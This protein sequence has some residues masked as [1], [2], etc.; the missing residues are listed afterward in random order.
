M[1]VLP[2]P[3]CSHLIRS[4]MAQRLT[5]ASAACEQL[6][7]QDATSGEVI[8]PGMSLRI[9]AC[10]INEIPPFPTLLLKRREEGI[11]QHARI[12]LHLEHLPDGALGRQRSARRGESYK[13]ISV[14]WRPESCWI[15]KCLQSAVDLYIPRIAWRGK[16][17][18]LG[19]RDRCV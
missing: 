12:H 9:P 19:G 11:D 10:H 6:C 2:T 16:R 8:P 5:I 18:R 17:W 3:I 7:S 4:A 14:H 1:S 13:L 15:L